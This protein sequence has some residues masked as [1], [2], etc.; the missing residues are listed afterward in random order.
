M[1]IVFK[2]RNQKI[3]MTGMCAALLAVLSQI[4]IPLPTGVPV[5][6]QTFAVA[7]CGY[8]LGPGLGTLS[9][10]VYLAMGAVGLPVFA[11]FSGGLGAFMGMAGGFLW[12]F[13]GMAFLCGLGARQG[14]RLIAIALGTAGLLICHVCGVAQFALLTGSTPLQATAAV[15]VP[16]LI[17]DVISVALACF[18][19]LA[20]LMSLKRA[21]LVDSL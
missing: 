7:L 5:T 9:V 12:G 2:S 13:L 20:V 10:V 19:A 15:S 18:A 3:V 11:G 4:S 21:H 8:I 1:K 14:N 6:L 16:Y 17:K